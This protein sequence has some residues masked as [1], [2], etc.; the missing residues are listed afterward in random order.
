MCRELGPEVSKLMVSG[1]TY[2]KKKAA[3]AATRII[4]KVPEL[5]EEF[6]DRV[7]PLLEERHHGE[8]DL[9]IGISE[10]LTGVMLATLALAEDILTMD[11][12]YKKPF[13]KH[14]NLL[15]REVSS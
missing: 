2:I 7:G 4:K 8:S 15:V 5:T 6:I 10:P 13:K 3:L 1:N 9:I 11:I 12:K 14:L